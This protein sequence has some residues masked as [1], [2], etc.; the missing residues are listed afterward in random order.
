MKWPPKREGALQQAPIPKLTWLVNDKS[1]HSKAQ[2]P[3]AHP[4]RLA[5]RWHLASDPA[6]ARSKRQSSSG[7]THNT[8]REKLLTNE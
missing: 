1:G 8:S 3:C 5:S 7:S 2:L 6:F 4:F